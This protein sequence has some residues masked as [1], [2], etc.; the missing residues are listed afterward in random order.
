M[1]LYYTQLIDEYGFIQ[2]TNCNLTKSEESKE[3]EIIKD[4]IYVTECLEYASVFWLAAKY[5]GN[6]VTFK[7]DGLNYEVTSGE[8]PEEDIWQ[9]LDFIYC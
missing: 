3:L 8:M 6:L 7:S 4:G 1:K 9:E 5:G 2:E